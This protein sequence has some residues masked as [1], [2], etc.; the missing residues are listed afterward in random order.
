MF[1][2]LCCLICIAATL[3]S[4]ATV[5]SQETRTATVKAEGM[6]PIIGGNLANAQ[7]KA[8]QDAQRM[9]EA[10]KQ[11]CR[12]DDV[13]LLTN[14]Q[15]TAAAIE[16]AVFKDQVS[17]S[18]PGDEVFIFFSCHGGRTADTNGD[19]RDGLDEYLVPYDGT[20]GKPETM[21]L[22]DTFARWVR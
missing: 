22:D 2:S 19:E 17:K 4:A 21:I 16:K 1:R 18:K 14:S 11:S 3:L 5:L 10:L 6:A 7:D 12:V 20:L 8:I 9:A 15:A 13:V